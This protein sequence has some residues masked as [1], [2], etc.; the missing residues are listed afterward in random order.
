MTARKPRALV[1]EPCRGRFVL[2]VAI[3]A[4]AAVIARADDRIAPALDL[5]GDEIPAGAAVRMGTVRYRGLGA[6]LVSK[7][8]P[9]FI[10]GDESLIAQSGARQLAI[11][12]AATGK[13]VRVIDLGE[14]NV[15]GL[16]LSPDRRS[17]FIVGYLVKE[18]PAETVQTVNKLDLDTGKVLQSVQFT[19]RLFGREQFAVTPDGRTIITAGRDGT[20]QLL[21]LTSGDQVLK[22]RIDQRMIEALAVSPDGKL[23]AV[24]AS[25][26]VYLWEWTAGKEPEKIA[27]GQK[28][29]K[30]PRGQ[31]VTALAFSPDG[32]IL[33][34]GHRSHTQIVLRDVKSR[35]VLHTLEDAAGNPM[36]VQSLAFTADGRSLIAGN[37]MQLR[38]QEIDCRMHEWDVAT[39]TIR[40]QF[41]TDGLRPALISVSA[42]G[43]WLAATTGWTEET[44]KVWDL[45]TGKLMGRD[46]PAHDGQVNSIHLPH[47]GS[48]AVTAA[49]DGTVRI[50]DTTTGKQQHLL[51]HARSVQGM[52]LSGDGRMIASSSMDNTVRLWDASTGNEIHRLPGHGDLGGRRAVGFAADGSSLASWGDDFYLR[53]WDVKTGKAL[54]ESRVVPPDMKLPEREDDPQLVGGSLRLNVHQAA[55]SA[56]AR[57]LVLVDSQSIS[58]FDVTTRQLK[59]KLTNPDGRT[60]SLAVSPNG[61]QVAT[62]SWGRPIRT[63]LADGTTRVSSEK[64]NLARVFDV[65]SGAERF[66]VELPEHGTGPIAFS[67]DGRLVAVTSQ[68]TNPTVRLLDAVSGDERTAI[69]DLPCKVG[70]ISFSADGRRLACGLHDGTVL[71]WKL[72]IPEKKQ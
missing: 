25:N 18:P 38:G 35:D 46:M 63:K 67:A 57:I 60:L 62:S 26:N 56:D 10:A 29:E 12:E 31:N 59:S 40:R 68:S 34:V 64:N 28:P 33:A 4:L 20:L 54:H 15:A 39:G 14:Q 19:E 5:Y 6:S 22:Y 3:L 71:V 16:S 52:A 66:H 37:S 48:V 7:I 42:D 43:H 11:L 13:R 23:F 50:W 70:A 72:K 36:H 65:A 1:T 69:P 21:D 51:R 27:G 41:D 45:R 55:L 44:V 2:P 61:E 8:P 30:I 58:I 24:G 9:L 49:G 32:S 53:I 47:D 17:A